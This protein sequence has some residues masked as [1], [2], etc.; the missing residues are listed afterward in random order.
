[1]KFLVLMKRFSTNKDLVIQNFGRQVRLFE[2]IKK[3]GHD[4]D[5]YCMDFKKFESKKVRKNNIDYYIEPFSFSKFNSFLKKLDSLLKQNKYDAIIAST[6]PLLGIIG[7]F[8]ARK[9]KTKIVYELQDSFD[10]Y[11]EYKIPF[12]KKL[13]NYI[14]KNSDVVIC[15][16]HALMNRIKK[17]RKKTIYVIE[18]GIERDLFKPIKRKIAREKLHLPKKAKIIVHI[19]LLARIKGYDIM[20]DSFK[21][22]RERYPD[23]YLLIS[24]EVYKYDKSINFKQKNIIFRK[25]PKREEVVLGIN[26]A[27][28]A[29]LPNPKNA[30]TEYS[31]PYKIVEYMACNVP[32]VATNVGD[33]AILLKKYKGSLCGPNAEDMGKKIIEKLESDKRVDYSKDMKRFDWEVLARKLNKILAA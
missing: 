14:T 18:N 16:S 33:V 28:V 2:N 31:F 26:A 20:I 15:V 13:D 21:K 3:F 22:V 4:V 8:Y 30:F 19:G 29:I 24:G 6:S 25:F 17:F 32:I 7:Y 23:T 5:F 10:V 12:I 9:Y 1:M 27:D 11:D